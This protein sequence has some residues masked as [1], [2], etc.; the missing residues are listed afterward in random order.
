MNVEV[1]REAL[2]ID[3]V[4]NVEK[5]GDGVSATSLSSPD[6]SRL[7]KRSMAESNVWK[8][9]PEA[10]KVGMSERS[11]SMVTLRGHVPHRASWVFIRSW[12]HECDHLGILCSPR[13]QWLTRGS[14]LM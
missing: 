5:I 9:G 13:K 12:L 1:M 7:L 4:V 10:G 11:L 6:I 8:G 2:L 3:K 14:E